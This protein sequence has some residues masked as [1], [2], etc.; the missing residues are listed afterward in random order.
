MKRMLA[1]T[2]AAAII[3]AMAP[4]ATRADSLVVDGLDTTSWVARDISQTNE[5][6]TWHKAVASAPAA[7]GMYPAN[8]WVRDG[9]R[10]T[11]LLLQFEC[12][13]LGEKGQ[14][15]YS[16]LTLLWVLDN[17]EDEHRKT[18]RP[19]IQLV[20]PEVHW[21]WLDNVG[22]EVHTELDVAIGSNRTWGKSRWE[23]KSQDNM[24]A[25]IEKGKA[26]TPVSADLDNMVLTLN[27]SDQPGML[28]SQ[29]HGL[30]ESEVRQM[31]NADVLM[32]RVPRGY[33]KK[34]Q[35]VEKN[36]MMQPESWELPQT[37][38]V[39]EWH[40]PLTG[41]REAIEQALAVCREGLR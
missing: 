9:E 19:H 4:T 17:R 34:S 10:R 18:L 36:G 15:P 38:G 29:G 3:G 6:W 31:Q 14:M 12:S 11:K 16:Y 5:S 26:V 25:V 28:G 35:M 37:Q 33:W 2:M 27:G 41:S 21:S 7:T 24:L 22:W 30:H 20:L 8:A 32:L 40:V 1:G 39:T 23:R 13:G